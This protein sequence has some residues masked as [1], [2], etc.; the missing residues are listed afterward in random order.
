MKV[1]DINP[2]VREVQIQSSVLEGDTLRFAFDHRIFYVLEGFGQ[3]IFSDKRIE[4]APDTLI[5]I[6]PNVGYYFYGK[7][8]VIVINFDPTRNACDKKTPLCPIKHKLKASNV[9]DDTVI[10]ELP[11]YLVTCDP[12]FKEHLLSVAK[13]FNERGEFLDLITSS[14]L[15]YIISEMVLRSKKHFSQEK[16]LA[17]KIY[18]YIRLNVDVIKS[19]DEIASHFGYHPVY[20]G[21]VFKKITGKTLHQARLE[22]KIN[23]A[24]KWLTQTDKSIEDI[25]F[26]VGFSSRNHF[27]TTFKAIMKTSPLQFRRKYDN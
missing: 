15:K 2:Y 17:E 3:I 27:C 8:K 10:E 16:A 14:R 11:D 24:C 13:D 26:G 19:N 25:A 4:V 22:E 21:N 9:Y 1:I 7:M 20:I 18:G 23:L 6:R 12:F 5:Y